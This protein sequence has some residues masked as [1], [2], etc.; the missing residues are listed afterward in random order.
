MYALYWN[1]R[2]ELGSQW[3]LHAFQ[4]NGMACSYILNDTVRQWMINADGSK[5]DASTELC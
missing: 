4:V 2:N 5:N 3:S 1:R